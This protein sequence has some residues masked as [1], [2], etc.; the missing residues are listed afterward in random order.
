AGQDLDEGAEVDDPLDHAVVGRADLGLGDEALDQP[1][2]ALD[3][4]DVAAGD[5]NPAGVLDVDRAAGLLDDRADGLAARPDDLADLVDLDLHGHD[6][7]RVLADVAA[8]LGH[9]LE[10]LAEDVQPGLARLV[11][12]GLEDLTGQAR[13]LDVHLQRGDAGAGA[14]DL[15]VHVAE[16]ILV[17]EDG[18]QVRVLAALLL[19]AHGDAGDRRLGRAAG[20][21]PTPAAYA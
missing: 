8:R 16:V 17:A 19:E 10:H 3:L 6:P 11:E 12:R 15:E 14:G 9:H 20:V 2:G 5:R 4:L 13:D 21:Q 7:R 1:L 18:G